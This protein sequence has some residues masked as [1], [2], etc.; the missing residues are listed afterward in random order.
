MKKEKAVKS[1]PENSPD[2][3]NNLVTLEGCFYSK[4]SFRDSGKL[5]MFSENPLTS[6]LRKA[7]EV[8]ALKKSFFLTIS[9]LTTQRNFHGKH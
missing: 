3:G 9:A 1:D 4:K 7:L 8:F 2:Y 5:F 6:F